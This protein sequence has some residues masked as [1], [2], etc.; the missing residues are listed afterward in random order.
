MAL[1]ISTD[2]KTRV[3]TCALIQTDTES[4]SV[5]VR[6]KSV[7]F[8]VV[9]TARGQHIAQFN[10]ALFAGNYYIFTRDMAE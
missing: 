9:F 4:V 3:H 10:M 8:V 6:V 2:I 5:I 1:H 7:F